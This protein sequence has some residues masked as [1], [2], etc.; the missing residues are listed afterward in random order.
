MHPRPA[1]VGGRFVWG[2]V[3]ALVDSEGEISLVTVALKALSSDRVEPT[4][5]AGWDHPSS[6]FVKVSSRNRYMALILDDG[7]GAP[8][9][10]RID[11]KLT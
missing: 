10:E 5:R 3:G 1:A 4:L 6:H 8:G 2:G 7:I 9:H 11:T